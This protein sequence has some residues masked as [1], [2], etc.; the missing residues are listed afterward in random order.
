MAARSTL[1]RQ[2]AMLHR[3]VLERHTTEIIGRVD[4]MWMDPTVHRVLGLICKAGL[5][6]GPRK[7][8][9]LDQIHAI[10]EDSL[11]LKSSPAEADPDRIEQLESLM[12]LEVW[13]ESGEKVG[14][15]TDCLFDLRTGAI[16][17]YLLVAEGWHRFTG[18]TYQIAPIQILSYGRQRAII[19][20]RAAQT[21][22]IYQ[23]GL[24]YKL[25]QASEQLR[26]E[27]TQ[28]A[29]ELQKLPHKAR[30]VVERTKDQ[31]A[32][33]TDLAAERARSL[34]DQ[35]A[36]KAQVLN[37]QLQRESGNWA[38]LAKQKGQSWLEQLRERHQAPTPSVRQDI[39]SIE[40]VKE[41]IDVPHETLGVENEAIWDDLNTLSASSSSQHSLPSTLPASSEN[42]NWPDEDDEDPW[43]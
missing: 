12:G 41:T 42:V 29:E 33:F 17:N 19:D 23:P 7:V 28:V 9:T 39:F 15:I 24:E 40:G 13:S 27:Y 3:L 2:N 14:I 8:F 5:L 6:G 38:E 22:E 1:V 11:I 34:A 25:S 21:L 30:D 18:D 10:G 37:R 36:E 20:E 26:E 35:A 31:V 32:T 43:I 16:R 4:L